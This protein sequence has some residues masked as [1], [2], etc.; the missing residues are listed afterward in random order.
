MSNQDPLITEPDYEK[1]FKEAIFHLRCITGSRNSFLPEVT[2]LLYSSD[3]LG[4]GFT[5]RSKVVEQM[6]LRAYQFCKEHDPIEKDSTE[7]KTMIERL[8]KP[9]VY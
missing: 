4:E 8:N 7:H 5:L 6:H 2:G 1:L 3:K 9:R